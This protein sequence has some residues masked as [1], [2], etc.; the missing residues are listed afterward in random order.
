MTTTAFRPL[1]EAEQ[2][3]KSIIWEPALRAGETY[4]ETTVT[5]LA[6]PIIKQVDEEII[7]LISEWAFNQLILFVDV[8]A[9][10]L[11]NAA[12]QS[13]Y[14]SASLHLKVIAIDKGI[15]SEEFKAERIKALAALS[16]FT[17]IAQ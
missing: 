11:V 15:N 13:V 6:L 8:T 17:R 5:F 3:F 9:I 7:L 1:T 4:L 2:I 16:D 12:H 10:Q 14:D